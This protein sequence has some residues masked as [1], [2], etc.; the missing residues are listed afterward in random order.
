MNNKEKFLLELLNKSGDVSVNSGDEDYFLFNPKG[1]NFE[2]RVPYNQLSNM[3]NVNFV[4]CI[5]GSTENGKQEASLTFS[6]VDKIPTFMAE[7][8]KKYSEYYNEYFKHTPFP[9]ETLDKIKDMLRT[10]MNASNYPYFI[11]G[12]LG[13]LAIKE[14]KEPH[15]IKI[16]LGQSIYGY[17]KPISLNPL[18]FLVID[19]FNKDEKTSLISKYSKVIPAFLLDQYPAISNI[20]NINK[21]TDDLHVLTD[22]LYQMDRNS[23]STLTSIILDI[24]LNNKKD[25]SKKHKI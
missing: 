10:P 13:P 24:E 2:V 4:F 19:C 6:S 15:G 3:V 12:Q 23:G 17:G 14:F 22:E 18:A 8:Y 7:I 16:T 1:V 20:V 25:V 11:E 5:P 21:S 9:Q